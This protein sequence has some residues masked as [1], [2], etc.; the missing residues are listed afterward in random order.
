MEARKTRVFTNLQ[1]NKSKGKK[2]QGKTE[3][4]L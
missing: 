2:I 4:L 3:V 1:A